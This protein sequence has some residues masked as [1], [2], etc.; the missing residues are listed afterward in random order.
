MPPVIKAPLGEAATFSALYMPK[1]EPPHRTL[2]VVVIEDARLLLDYYLLMLSRVRRLVV[3]NTQPV[4]SL[5]AALAI[6]EE[7]KPDV[8][9][10]DLCLSRTG[11]EGFDILKEVRRRYPGTTVVLTTAIYSPDNHDPLNERI[12]TEGFDAV[13]HKLDLAHLD[14]FL[15][16]L[17]HQNLA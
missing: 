16:S 14:M 13:F 11:V 4:K 5:E 6:I 15:I 10:T 7:K 8:V 9:I 1:S 2:R 3:V 17:M 12:R